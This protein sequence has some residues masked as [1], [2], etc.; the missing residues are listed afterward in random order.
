MC[1]KRTGIRAI[2]N[3]RKGCFLLLSALGP[4]AG[5]FKFFFLSSNAPIIY[6]LM[7]CLFYVDNL[8]ES[9]LRAGVGLHSYLCSLTQ[10]KIY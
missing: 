9:L 6:F 7:L 8:F 5:N 4:A 1:M 3:A 10:S 2:E